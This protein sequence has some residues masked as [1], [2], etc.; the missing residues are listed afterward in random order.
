MRLRAAQ[1]WME[2][3]S[4]A[5]AGREL[6]DVPVELHLHPAVLMMRHEVLAAGRRWDEAAEIALALTELCPEMPEAW[7]CLAYATRRRTEGSIQKAREILL[8]AEPEFPVEYLFPFNLACYSSQ[9][10]QFAE[11]EKW[12]KKAMAINDDRVKRMALEDEDLKPFWDNI[13][14]QP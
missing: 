8:T 13:G 14:G 3:G 11:T 10:G 5:E 6:D 2:L 12:L 7:I 1:G 9:M 4:L